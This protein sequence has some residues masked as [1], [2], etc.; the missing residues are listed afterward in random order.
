MLGYLKCAVGHDLLF[1]QV[2]NFLHAQAAVHLDA[3]Q[4]HTLGDA[5][6]L[7]G[8]HP[9]GFPDGVVGLGYGVFNF[10]DIKHGLRAVS[11]ND[12]HRISS[13]TSAKDYI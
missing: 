12:L 4:L 10:R 11:L 13:L 1:H 8:S 2:L 7:H 9:L 6:D 5:L 3:G